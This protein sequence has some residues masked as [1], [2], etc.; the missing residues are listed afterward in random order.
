MH[1][2][3]LFC[4]MPG[5][6]QEEVVNSPFLEKLKRK[7]YEVIYFTDA[8]DE[9]VM[10]NMAEYEGHKFFD[11]SKED[12]KIGK[13]KAEKEAEKKVKVRPALCRHRPALC[14]CWGCASRECALCVS[15]LFN[16]NLP[17][18]SASFMM[19]RKVSPLLPH[20]CRK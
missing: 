19:T 18:H 1:T 7:D 14:V 15:S 13:D 17:I 5:R 4:F 8:L 11:A 2:N 10:S 12:L 20:G 3:T 16:G 9:Y 6:S